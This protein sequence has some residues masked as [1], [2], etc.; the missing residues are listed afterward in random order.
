MSYKTKLTS[1][2]TDNTVL[3]AIKTFGYALPNY[4]NK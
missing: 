2:T 3:I 1:I 4:L